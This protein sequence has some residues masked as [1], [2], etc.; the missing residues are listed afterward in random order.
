MVLDLR[1]TAQPCQ[2]TQNLPTLS[3]LP[4]KSVNFSLF[5]HFL[6]KRSPIPTAC[7]DYFARPDPNS[8]SF[9][10]LN[11]LFNKVI[12]FSKKY[13]DEIRVSKLVSPG[14]ISRPLFEIG[15]PWMYAL[16]I[17]VRVKYSFSSSRPHSFV[18]YCHR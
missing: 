5:P 12:F 7:R 8:F 16:S 4:K 18:S 2:L 14:D 10:S 15:D 1:T 9:L 13:F 17:L 6:C 3:S 11:L